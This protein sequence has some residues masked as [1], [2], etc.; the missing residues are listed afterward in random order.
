MTDSGG[1]ARYGYTAPRLVDWDGDGDLDVISSD[2]TSRVLL[3][4]NVGTKTNPKL[5]V[6]VPL[7]ADGLEVHGPWRVQPWAG[8]LGTRTALVT[9][10][11][12]GRGVAQ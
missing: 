8:R 4:R 12:A 2:V 11:D 5:A 3:Y 7:M 6:P 1:K 9:L 10:D